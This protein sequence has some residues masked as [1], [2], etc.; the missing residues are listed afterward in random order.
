VSLSSRAFEPKAFYDL[1]AYIRDKPTYMLPGGLRQAVDSA[2][3]SS[4]YAKISIRGVEA[5]SR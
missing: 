1:A 4:R 5:G 3:V 2:A